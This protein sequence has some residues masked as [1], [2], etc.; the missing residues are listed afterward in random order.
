MV[1]EISVNGNRILERGGEATILIGGE[2]VRWAKDF[3]FEML[4]KHPGANA[5][6][7]IWSALTSDVCASLKMQNDSLRLICS[8]I[9]TRELAPT[10]GFWLNVWILQQTSVEDLPVGWWIDLGKAII[11]DELDRCADFYIAVVIDDRSHKLVHPFG[12]L[13]E[14]RRRK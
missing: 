12:V 10:L 5:D 11:L 2:S 7:I 1:E 8:I 6:V 14:I 4:G 13:T 9:R 3:C